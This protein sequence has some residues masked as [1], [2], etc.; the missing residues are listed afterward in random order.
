MRYLGIDPGSKGAMCALDPI[1]GR[2]DFID[3]K[4]PDWVVWKWLTL[5]R[6]RLEW[7]A[8]EEVHSLP[9]MSAKSNFGFGRQIGRV[10]T[11][12]NLVEQPF[13]LI[14][15]KIWQK[16]C[17]IPARKD[18]KDG[19]LKLAVAHKAMELYPDSQEHLF[20]PRGGLIDGRSDALLI[21]HT[22]Y[23]KYEHGEL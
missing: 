13:S 19:D 3:L 16:F 15:P 5:K 22:C 11:M 12:L 20:G 4:Y 18:I 21:A 23:L 7:A 9:G 14:K 1:S 10:H 6:K 17:Q 2:V 8:V